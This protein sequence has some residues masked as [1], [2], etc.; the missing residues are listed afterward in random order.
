MPFEL[1]TEFKDLDEA[2]AYLQSDVA[3][4]LKCLQRVETEA[5]AEKTRIIANR[6]ELRSEKKVLQEK[7]TKAEADLTRVQADS[8][9]VQKGA[10]EA[11]DLEASQVCPDASAARGGLHPKD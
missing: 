9:E 4:E 3:D 1:K 5:E 8:A 7:L 6:D 11:S 2:I 10:G